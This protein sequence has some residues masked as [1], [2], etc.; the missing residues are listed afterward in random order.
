MR[1]KEEKTKRKM[2]ESVTV[3]WRLLFLHGTH[4]SFNCCLYRTMASI[5]AAAASAVDDCECRMSGRIA[6]YEIVSGESGEEVSMSRGRANKRRLRED[7]IGWIC[8]VAY[9][10]TEYIYINLTCFLNV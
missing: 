6:L 3:F 2:K 7:L 5:R 4:F 1:K 8:Q 9:L 10:I